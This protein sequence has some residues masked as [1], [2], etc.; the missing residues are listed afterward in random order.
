[1]HIVDQNWNQLNGITLNVWN[2]VGLFF[3]KIKRIV[4]CRWII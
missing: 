1:M 2:V 4:C 3:K